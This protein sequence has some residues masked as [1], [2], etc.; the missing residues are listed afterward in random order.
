M[1]WDWGLGSEQTEYDELLT[2]RGSVLDRWSLKGLLVTPGEMCAI[3]G[4][5]KSSDILPRAIN[6]F[7][8]ILGGEEGAAAEAVMVGLLIDKGLLNLQSAE[9][10]EL[11]PLSLDGCK[12]R[13]EVVKQI[14]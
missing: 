7:T 10:S 11:S 9:M 8:W 4:F 3:Q 1:V 6:G 5:K 13:C 2:L 14:A 12:R